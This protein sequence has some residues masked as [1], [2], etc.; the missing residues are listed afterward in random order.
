MRAICEC[1]TAC[2]EKMNLGKKNRQVESGPRQADARSKPRTRSRLARSNT[3]FPRRRTHTRYYIYN[4]NTH[5][6]ACTAENRK[7]ALRSRRH[8]SMNAPCSCIFCKNLTTTLLLGRIRTC[9]RPRFS[10]LE[11]V[12]K[13]SARTDMRTIYAATRRGEREVSDTRREPSLLQQKPAL[14]PSTTTTQF[15]AVLPLQPELTNDHRT[16]LLAF[17]LRV[18]SVDYVGYKENRLSDCNK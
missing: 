4:T 6:Y 12:F 16:H 7:Q 9:R 2:V 5:M 13:Q 18:R 11:M 10:A 15:L 14:S 8:P 17:C 1:D 3:A